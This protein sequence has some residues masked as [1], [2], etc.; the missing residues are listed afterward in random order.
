MSSCCALAALSTV[1]VLV[2][3]VVPH[4]GGCLLRRVNCRGLKNYLYQLGGSLLC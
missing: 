3:F 1:T 2:R 4:R